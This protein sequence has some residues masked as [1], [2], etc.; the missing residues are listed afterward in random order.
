MDFGLNPTDTATSHSFPDCLDVCNH[1]SL[2]RKMLICIALGMHATIHVRS[3][4]A[5]CQLE[6]QTKIFFMGGGSFSSFISK[7]FIFS[8]LSKECSAKVVEI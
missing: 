2:M 6:W 1:S 7:E 3:C 5:C 8:G 4:V